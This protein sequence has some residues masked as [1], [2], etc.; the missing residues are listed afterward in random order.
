MRSIK[1][2]VIIT[3]FILFLFTV[4][5]LS[6]SISQADGPIYVVSSGDS[7]LEIAS[8]FNV[9][10]QELMES[11]NISDPNQ[12]FPG[13][14]LI[15]PGLEGISGTLVSKIVPFGESQTSIS[16]HYRISNDQLRKLN[17]L[18][19]PTEFYA[20]ANLIVLDDTDKITWTS[21]THLD[22]GISLLELSIQ[23]GTDPW[24]LFEI[25]QFNK[26]WSAIP[27]D[28]LFLPGSD[29]ESTQTGLPFIF[30]NSVVSPLPLVQGNTVQI[31]I[32]TFPEVTLSGQLIDHSLKFHPIATDQYI[33]LQGIHAL[34]EP[35]LYPLRLDGTLSSGEH[36]SF[37][38]MILVESGY[39]PSEVIEVDPSY[40]DPAITIPE[41]DFIKSLT[42]FSNPERYWEGRF[43]SPAIEYESTS[44]LTSKYGIR[45]KYFGIG[46]DLEVDG[47][48]T[49]L[50]FGGGTGLPV[51]APAKGKVIF[52]GPL[53]IRG[54]AT[55]I[56]HGW[57]I[58]SGFWH[59]SEID[60]K[61]GDIVE[62][63]QIIGLVG[64]TGRVTG[65][66]LHWEIWV[67]RVQVEPLEW[68][69]KVFPIQ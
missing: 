9:T 5:V 52:A 18:I 58:Y 68:L 49:G 37:E 21:R 64:G 22:P 15:I 19:S 14:Q 38:Q 27:G 30:I 55:I 50:D 4:P 28:I 20:G 41:E 13:D 47:F 24:T 66:H 12:L 35:G 48:H 26:S 60:V 59:Q 57:G 6:K 33:A 39:Y 36:Y 54:N 32:Q 69:E 25:N 11:N 53:D 8:R 43:I 67:N 7:L 40:I 16:R 51:T 1:I 45:R 42:S 63:G 3:V 2:K 10:L 61:E 65:P 31:D 23:H 29:N 62:P 56:D 34:T 17:H 46:T 44:Y